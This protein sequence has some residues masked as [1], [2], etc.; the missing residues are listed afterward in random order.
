MI[1]EACD[2]V[3]ADL[4]LLHEN[5]P[6]RSSIGYRLGCQSAFVE[7]MVSYISRF[8]IPGGPNEGSHPL[9][10]LT[11]RDASDPALALIG[12]WACTLDVLSFYQER[13]ANEGYIRTATERRSIMELA[14]EIGYELRPGVAASVDLAFTVEDAPG[15]PGSATVPRKA[16]AM[17]VPGQGEMPQ[18]FETMEDI[19][20][21]AAWNSICP[22]LEEPQPLDDAYTVYY[23]EGLDQEAK[24]GSFVVIVDGKNDPSPKQIVS[25]TRE[26]LLNR[27]RIDLDLVANVPTY[28]AF[29][30]PVLYKPPALAKLVMD[31]ASIQKV[32]GK[33]AWREKDLGT[34]LSIQ[35]WKQQSVVAHMEKIKPKFVVSAT[36]GPVIAISM[37]DDK[38]KLPDTLPGLYAFRI[39]SAPFGHNAPYNAKW[40]GTNEPSIGQELESGDWYKGFDLYLDRAVPEVVS[41][42]W[43][44][45]HG[46]GEPAAYR[47]FSASEVSMMLPMYSD[48]DIRYTAMRVTGIKLDRQGI[49]SDVGWEEWKEDHL[50][51]FKLRS[52]TI[53]VVSIPLRLAA[54]PVEA[55][56]GRGTDEEQQV[57]LDG[58]VF[59]LS[60]GQ[61]V[62]VSGERYDPEGV[63]EVEV[64]KIS[65][66][67]HSGGFTT[68]FFES[69][70]KHK[71]VR[72]TFSINANV[73]S[74]THGETGEEVLGSGD[75]SKANQRFA[76]KRNPLTYVSSSDPRGCK[77][78]IEVRVDD[79]LWEERESLYDLG[80]TSRSYMVR[81]NHE[82]KA[83]VI[84]GDGVRGARLSS[85]IEN[86][87]AV[88]RSGIGLAGN[89]GADSIT[90][91]PARPQGIRSVTN[92]NPAS[93]GAEPES[94]D[95][96]RENAP[97]TVMTMGRIVSLRDYED[98]ASEFAGIGKAQATAFKRGE[99]LLVHLT[100]AAS[101]QA[102]VEGSTG[103]VTHMIDPGSALFE[104]LV[105]AI[106]KASDPFQRF[107]VSVYDPSFFN[108]KAKVLIDPKY[109][110]DQ[111][112]S[113][114]LAA[115]NSAFSFSSRRFGQSASASEAL[116]VM[117]R[118]DGVV[119][120]DLDEFYMIEEETDEA[121]A[122]ARLMRTDAGSTKAGTA[123]KREVLESKEAR[124]KGSEIEPS[125]L[126]LINPLGISLSEMIL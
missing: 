56:I 40:D 109:K 12:A 61:V 6:G 125:Q 20:V 90:L 2:V 64:A 58:M 16:K 98:F 45:L 42:G 65:D 10:L 41:G 69:G 43:L 28:K 92:P 17:S 79:L 77:S 83:E 11:T 126:L 91:M 4:D 118:V 114:V 94:R 39:R 25:V 60:E 76:L 88:Y 47:V 62:I 85:G 21:R 78:T 66:I 52:T 3:E 87:S 68:I 26:E 46:M 67:V 80:R 24:V 112:L 117:Q 15:A 101:A 8:E 81:I 116:S 35:G 106:S 120:V 7:R 63:H 123:L 104:N 86:V 82:N 37:E 115:L 113:D 30:P 71:Y 36:Y 50:N 121:G 100:I 93:G 96:A 32:I 13:I 34:Y 107:A 22:R 108:L 75:G 29:K 19:V 103:P 9:A 89:V 72:S 110:K 18:T 27:I 55:C 1:P 14:R 70:L 119:A 111:V 38:S 33:Q 73:A 122:D 95:G 59:G 44:L 49:D 102:L 99:T 51:S 84:F 105:E 53:M 97:R 23:L 31:K 74:A 5:P 54:L 124:M 48:T 57:T